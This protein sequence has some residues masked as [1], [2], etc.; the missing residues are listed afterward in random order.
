[1]TDSKLS[2]T[3]HYLNMLVFF[4]HKHRSGLL[5]SSKNSYNLQYPWMVY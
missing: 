1:M 4:F 3:K 5:L 2:G